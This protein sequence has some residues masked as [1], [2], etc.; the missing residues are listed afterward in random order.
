MGVFAALGAEALALAGRLS[1]EAG[2]WILGMRCGLLAGRR[3]PPQCPPLDADHA[4]GHPSRRGSGGMVRLI[5]RAGFPP[6]D[7]HRIFGMAG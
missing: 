4:V 2:T 5:G 6:P 3:R 1:T 7:A